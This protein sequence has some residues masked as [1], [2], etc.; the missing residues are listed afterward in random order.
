MLVLQHHLNPDYPGEYIQ[1]PDLSWIQ[2]TFP[3]SGTRYRLT[4][5]EPLV[6]RYRIV[7]HPGMKPDDAFSSRMW[8]EYNKES[9]HQLDFTIPV[10]Q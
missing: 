6:L 3:A 4:P 2:P 5:G 7:V 1:Y 8:D 10:T 9:T